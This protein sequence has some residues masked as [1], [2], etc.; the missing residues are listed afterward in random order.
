MAVDEASAG[1]VTDQQLLWTAAILLYGVG[2]TVTT[3]W[4]LSTSGVAE[5]GPVASPVIE[6]YG[7]Y[8]LVALKLVVVSTFYLAWRGV[9]SIGRAAIPLALAT[10]G[11]VVSVWN[12]ATIL[13]L[14]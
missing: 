4:G 1:G 10:V 9:D 13:V 2:D 12:L 6:S 7:R 11:G 14:G 8:G 3:L 5:A